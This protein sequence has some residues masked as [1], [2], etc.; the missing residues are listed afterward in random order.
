MLKA[1]RR[2]WR[3]VACVCSFSCFYLISKI[4]V[5]II[6]FCFRRCF[7]VEIH[8]ALSTSWWINTHFWITL[9]SSISGLYF[10]KIS[11]RLCTMCATVNPYAYTREQLLSLWSA[12]ESLTVPRYVRICLFRLCIWRP[13]KYRHTECPMNENYHHAK[14]NVGHRNKA[15]KIYLC[16]G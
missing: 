6:I 5:I 11:H 14:V 13:R 15:K 16:L 12:G 2:E 9:S 3:H 7:H 8:I 10:Q 1:Q 4:S